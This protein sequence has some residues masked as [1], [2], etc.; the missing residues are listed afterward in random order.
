MIYV[1]VSQNKSVCSGAEP[2]THIEVD[3]LSKHTQK[4]GFALTLTTCAS[5]WITYVM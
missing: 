5:S 3:N 2:D 1:E 4:L